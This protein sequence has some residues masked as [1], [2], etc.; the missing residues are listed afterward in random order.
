M[1][2][3]VTIE[4]ARFCELLRTE[5]RLDEVIASGACECKRCDAPEEKCFELKKERDELAARLQVAQDSIV[6]TT[7]RDHFGKLENEYIKVCKE[8]GDLQTKLAAAISG[9]DYSKEKEAK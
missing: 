7:E 4:E 2:N 1:A 6:S 5:K 9:R 8:R 3:M